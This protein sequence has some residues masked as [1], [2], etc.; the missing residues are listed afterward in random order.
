MNALKVSDTFDMTYKAFHQKGIRQLVSM[1]G[2]RSSKSYSILQ[3]L[4]LELIKRKNIKITV[5]RNTKVTCRA[6]VME[7]FKN[8]IMFDDKVFKKFKENKQSGTF[9]Y[10]PTGSRIIFEGADDI[11]KVLGSQQDISFFNEVTEFSKEVYLQITQRTSDRVIC[12][13]N[14]SKDFWL[15]QYRHDTETIFIRTNFLNNAFCPPN[16]VKQLLSYEPWVPGSYEVIDAEVYYKGKPITPVNQPPANEANIKKGT[17]SVYMWMVYGLGLGTEKPNKIYHGWRKITQERFDSLP[18]PSYFGL[19]FG[20]ANPTACVE[21]K[22][23]GN[24]GMYIC[25]RLYKPLG[26]IQDSLVTVIKLKVPQIVKG[27]SWVICDPA[28][29]AYLDILN[30]DGYI[31]IKAT[32]GSGSIEAGISIVQSL[33]VYYV[34][35]EHL[36]S[37]YDHYSYQVDRNNKPTDVPLK[38]NDHLMDAARY[39]I[40]FLYRYLNI[41]I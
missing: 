39:V 16:I 37:E 6:T 15:E 33:T 5:W 1:G 13:Y 29:E 18:Y 12:D 11:G 41:K 34:D 27:K 26:E 38:V 30:N 19:D 17:A 4:M 8:I 20:T 40:T 22:Y 10:I 2:S 21:V 36:G 7:D 3:M 31:A 28:K 35:S 32:K 24:G 9:T 25:E 23:D 14:P